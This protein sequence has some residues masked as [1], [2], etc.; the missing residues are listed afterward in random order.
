MLVPSAKKTAIA[1]PAGV[2]TIQAPTMGC[3]AIAL[4]VATWAVVGRVTARA[5][6]SAP[7]TADRSTER[8]RKM[9]LPCFSRSSHHGSRRGA[10]SHSLGLQ[11]GA[12]GVLETE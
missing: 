11:L 2:V 5:L 1:R 4:G 10:S 9:N 7:E 12:A 8:R 3:S 6:V